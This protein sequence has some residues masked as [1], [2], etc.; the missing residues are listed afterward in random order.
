M[1]LVIKGNPDQA[2]FAANARGVTLAGIRYLPE[3]DQTEAWSNDAKSDV[4]VRWY[5]AGISYGTAFPCDV[6]ELLWFRT[7]HR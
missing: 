6:G 1:Y 2:G 5:A 7:G 4:L 3:W